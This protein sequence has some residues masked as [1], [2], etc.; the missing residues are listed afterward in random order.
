MFDEKTLEIE[1]AGRSLKVST[2]KIARQSCGAI[3]IQ[4]GD[5]VLLSTVNRSKEARKGVDFF[6]L[7]VDYIEKFYAAGKFPGGFN[8]R[9]SRP[10]T[11]ATLIARLIDRPIRPMFPEGFTYDV[12]IV[13]TVFSFDE[14]NTPDYLGI[15]ASSLAL[16]ISDIPFLGPVAGVVVGYIDGEFVLNPTPEQL[17]KSLLDLSVA[18][19]KEAVNMV[20]A[21][22]KELDEETMLKAIL[23]AHENIKKICAFQ[24][25]FVKICGKEKITFEKEEVDPMISSF[26]EEHGHERLQQAVLTLGKKNREEA[27]DSLE[28][29]LLEAFV[30]KHYPEIPEEEL[31]EEPILAF[32]KYYHDL[33]KTLV[34]EAILYKK[35]RVDGRSTTEIR[36]LDAQ[37]NV[38]PIPHGSALFTRGETQSLATATLG[39]K[40]DEQLV[41]NLEKEYYKKFYLHYNFPPY[42]VG[43]TGRMG[44][45]GRR[46]LGHGSLAERALRY[47]IPTEEEFPYTI[48]V[49]SDITESNGSSSQASIC[50]GSLALMSAGVPIKE[51]VAGIAMGLIKEGEEFTVLTDIMGLEDHLGDMDFKVAGTKSGITAL[52]MDIKI[53]GITE[54]IMRIALSQAHVARQQILEVMNAAI[55]SPADLKPNVP[56]I[57][58]IMIPKDKIA[59]LIG[60][61][62]KNIKGIIEETGS[63]IDI[64]D[65]GKV[66]I[67][68]KDAD[69]LE[70]TLRLVN[71]YVKD[72][73]LNEVYEGKVVGIQKFGA[74]MEILPGK[75]GLL[76]ISEISKERVSNVEDVLKIGDVFKVKVISMENGKIAL[77]KKKLD[78]E[79]KVAE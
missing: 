67:F 64:T 56:R 62:G 23:F 39:T 74:F 4:Y 49:V 36:P 71:N 78:V 55:S 37:I 14:K 13:N 29:E 42:S 22:A 6:P 19:T 25:E 26:I 38:L 32:K 47:V 75:E 77:S 8:K 27:V 5:T 24:E 68:S 53:T 18:G 1:L 2:G 61:A 34:R 51:H 31:P 73:E 48:R 12:H 54:E 70:H 45:P 66:S 30:A 76:H 72:V 63:T 20:E 15:I 11:D 79:Y 65:D 50:G 57:Q 40:E 60:P 7:T 43:E 9:E 28:E 33:M 16:S 69:V 44:A 10:S 17:E 41:D 21:G 58:Q 59:I 35:H 3:M 46:E 52:Q